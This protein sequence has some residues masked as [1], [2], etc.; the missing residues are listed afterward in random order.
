M[1]TSADSLQFGELSSV[2]EVEHF[3]KYIRA[4]AHNKNELL[5]CIIL[6]ILNHLRANK[7]ENVLKFVCEKIKKY[8]LKPS[9]RRIIFAE[10][11]DMSNLYFRIRFVKIQMNNNLFIGKCFSSNI[12][13]SILK[14]LILLIFLMQ[15]KYMGWS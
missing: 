7:A 3:N 10:G 1:K 13:A 15:R 14:M 2:T 11:S 8:L 9:S 4:M 6:A 5:G 12:S